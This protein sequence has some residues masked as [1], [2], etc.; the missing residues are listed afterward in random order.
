[1]RK[2]ARLFK[3]SPFGAVAMAVLLASGVVGVASGG[4][5]TSTVPGNTDAS[6]CTLAT[7][8]PTTPVGA[9]ATPSEDGAPQK[10]CI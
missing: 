8:Y 6:K 3:G 10:T 5:A 2:L 1:M 9:N 7:G 4:A